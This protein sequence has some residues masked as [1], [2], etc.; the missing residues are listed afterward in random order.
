MT[1][2]RTH[3][4]RPQNTKYKLAQPPQNSNIDFR[5]GVLHN[6][7]YHDSC[8]VDPGYFIILLQVTTTNKYQGCEHDMPAP[9][10]LT[11]P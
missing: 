8:N 4:T 5:K 1:K 10:T 9:I 6:L 7:Q 11:A 2:S 3:N